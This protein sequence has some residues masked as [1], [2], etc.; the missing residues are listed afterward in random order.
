MCIQTLFRESK[1][2]CEETLQKSRNG[3]FLGVHGQ[4]ERGRGGPR[5]LQGA[6]HDTD[7]RAS[8]MLKT[9]RRMKARWL[10]RTI[11][12]CILADLTPDLTFYDEQKTKKQAG[13]F[14]RE[15]KP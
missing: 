3:A 1:S 12:N 4:G 15:R 8:P 14:Q 5:T 13:A 7:K 2:Q 10:P 9:L 11:T 6:R